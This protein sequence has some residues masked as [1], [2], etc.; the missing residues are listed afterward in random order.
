MVT[1]LDY[2]PTPPTPPF[3]RGAGGLGAGGL[4]AGGVGSQRANHVRN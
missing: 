1:I 3:T 4:G 2:P